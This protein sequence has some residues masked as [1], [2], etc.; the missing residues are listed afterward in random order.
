MLP[1]TRSPSV[2]TLTD[3]ESFFT[4]IEVLLSPLGRAAL[5]AVLVSLMLWHPTLSKIILIQ[6]L[7]FRI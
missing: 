6:S 5:K 1:L 4:R 7:L 3:K 2:K